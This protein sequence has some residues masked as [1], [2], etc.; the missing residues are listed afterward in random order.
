MERLWAPWRSRFIYHSKLK[1]CL[2]CQKPRSLRDRRNLVIER[3]KYVFSMLNLYPYNNGHFMIA[4]YRHIAHLTLL[5][6]RESGELFEMLKR[7]LKKLDRVL[8]PHG[9]NVG[10]NIGRAGGAGYH[11]HIH[12]HGVPR[13]QGDTN[14]MPVL[15][16]TKVMI[17]SLDEMRKRLLSKKG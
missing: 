15:N 8:K 5:T 10:F 1:G 13:W 9:Y 3:G 6:S 4:P 2:F 7:T 14:F 17:E 16:D 11:R 12:L